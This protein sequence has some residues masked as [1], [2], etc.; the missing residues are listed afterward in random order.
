M[1]KRLYVGSLPLDVTDSQ[2]GAMFAAC[3]TVASAK[4]ITD[5][6]TGQSRG[7]G[8]V[9]MSTDEEAQE[10]IKKMH[11][12]SAGDKQLVVNEARPQE[13]RP[14]SGFGGRGGF[15]GGGYGGRGDYGGGKGGGYGGKGGFPGR[16]GSRKGGDRRGGGH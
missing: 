11:D 2:L 10:A 15:G 13:E 3:G 1:G 4:V 7:F 12:S 16:G 6:T 14:K 8:F 5:K 9:E